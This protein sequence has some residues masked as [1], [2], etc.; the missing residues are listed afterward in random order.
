MAPLMLASSQAPTRSTSIPSGLVGIP[1][2]GVQPIAVGRLI[3]VSGGG[4][5][6]PGTAGRLRRRSD[7]QHLDQLRPLLRE[8]GPRAGRRAEDVPGRRRGS[9][10]VALARAWSRNRR[11]VRAGFRPAPRCR[12]TRAGRTPL[13]RPVAGTADDRRRD[14]G[15]LIGDQNRV[16][17]QLLGNRHLRAGPDDHL[18]RDRDLRRRRAAQ[19]RARD[20][21]T[22]GRADRG[23]AG[24]LPVRGRPARERRR[25]GGRRDDRPPAPRAG[26]D[27]R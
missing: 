24:R 9:G 4:T 12:P 20:L 11:G 23:P 21:R 17:L 5:R 25:R 16:D 8:R 13:R 6:I 1:L 22:R 7:D 15:A 19:A 26:G 27:H 10:P 14:R 18:R 2:H 3:R